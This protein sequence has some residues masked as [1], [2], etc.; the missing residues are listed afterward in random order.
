MRMPDK[1]PTHGYVG[2]CR[3]CNAVVA[4]TTDE[5][6]RTQAT[7]RYVAEFIQDGL[8][9]E[10]FTWQQYQ[11]EICNEETFF[12][13]PHGKPEKAETLPLFEDAT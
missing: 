11:D 7:A 9:V 6:H 2:R 3:E 12:K 4:I 1:K 13:C 10:R 8:Y 5:E